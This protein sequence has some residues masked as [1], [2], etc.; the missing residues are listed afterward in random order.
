MDTIK[1]TV[2]ANNFFVLDFIK[3]MGVITS[4]INLLVFSQRI[5]RQKP[6]LQ[7]FLAMSLSDV[8]YSLIFAILIPISRACMWQKENNSAEDA[9]LK[10]C[11]IASVLFIMLSDYLASCLALF[12]ISIEIFV[13]CQRVIIVSR[14][15]TANEKRQRLRPWAICLLIFIVSLTVYSPVLLMNK[16]QL[17]EIRNETTGAVRRDY[18]N[19]KNEFGRTSGGLFIIK[20][21]TLFR[22]FL[23]TVV[24]T[25]VNIIASIKFTA[26]LKRKSALKETTTGLFYLKF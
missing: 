13:T 24:L 12:N 17:V 19:E 2:E 8:I 25:V 4:I 9:D 23:V 11:Y 18:S 1:K 14:D 6:M 5:M 20:L 16:V 15:L 3:Y 10:V 26:F 22:M 21:V 7:F